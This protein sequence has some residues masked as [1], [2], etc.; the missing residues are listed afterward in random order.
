MLV[1][2][3]EKLSACSESS[4]LAATGHDQCEAMVCIRGGVVLKGLPWKQRLELRLRIR[5][6]G[7]RKLYEQPVTNTKANAAAHDEYLTLDSDTSS[8]TYSHQSRR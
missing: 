1:Q 5:S 2:Q 7:L 6:R 3:S 8:R 4:V